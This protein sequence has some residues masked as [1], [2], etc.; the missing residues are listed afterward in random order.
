MLRVACGFAAVA[1]SSQVCGHD[2]EVLGKPGR[3]FVPHDVSLRVPVEQQQGRAAAANYTVNGGAGG[4]HLAL[5][6]TFKH[7]VLPA[8]IPPGRRRAWV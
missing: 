4:L 6:K 3:D 1:V 7:I 8:P 5:L 2:S